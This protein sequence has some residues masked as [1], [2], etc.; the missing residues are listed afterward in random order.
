MEKVAFQNLYTEEEKLRFAQC[1][2]LEPGLI[3]RPLFSIVVPVYHTPVR[4]LNEMIASVVCQSYPDW[5]LCITN[6]GSE[7][8]RLVCALEYWMG[9]D[10][11]IRVQHL[12]VNGGISSN[13]NAC[14]EMAQG[15][16]IAMLD[17]DDLLTENALCEVALCL[18]EDPS[19]DFLYSDQD[20]ID[21]ES[22]KRFNPLY[23]PAWSKDMM[24][25]GNYITH[26]SVLRTSLI[27]EIGGWDAATD[28]A[29]DWD[30]FLRAAEHTDKIRGIPRILYHW[31]MAST[32]TASSMDT[33]RY[34]L[35]A[36]LRT[37]RRHLW[38]MGERQAEVCF[39]NQDIFKIQIHWN[40][41]HDRDIS[42]ILFDEE[43]RGDL[44]RTVSLIRVALRLRERE[45]IVLSDN[46][47]RLEVLKES[48]ATCILLPER[49]RWEEGYNAGAALASGEILLFLTDRTLPVT[50]DTLF[51]LADWAL[52]DKVAVAAP[53]IMGE[54]KHIKEM[55]IA[56]ELDGPV[57]MFRGCF[58]DGTTKCGKNYWYRDVCAVD[59]GCFAVKRSTHGQVGGFR[60][61]TALSMVEYCLKL[62]KNGYRHLVSPYAEV[63]FLG[64]GS[65]MCDRL[66]GEIDRKDWRDFVLA[67]GLPAED[68]Y[69]RRDISKD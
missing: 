31:R 43:Q 2:A 1:R 10:K 28:G 63:H 58:A 34:A 64:E 23:K 40:R 3:Y 8:E 46:K 54:G 13:T 11:R 57:S 44:R 26:F 47:D 51:E 50:R 12:P 60:E 5:E 16:Y 48:G 35:E 36:Q 38:R 7:D 67:W 61:K 42:V 27:R 30:I 41:K 22:T 32:S 53:K 4:L 24:Y 25:S 56:L 19:L 17:H 9:Q 21:E 49:R 20:M 15:E 45:M 18:Q 55:G 52:Y 59:Y 14:L 39:Y 33:K 65:T 6:A 29:Q 69:Y 66:K 68:P 62:I 37:I